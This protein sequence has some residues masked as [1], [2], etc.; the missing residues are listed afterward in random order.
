MKFFTD[1]LHKHV[2]SQFFYLLKPIKNINYL[3][4]KNKVPLCVLISFRILTIYQ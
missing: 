2:E 4:G 1:F 3:S